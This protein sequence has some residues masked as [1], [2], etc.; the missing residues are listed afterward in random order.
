VYRQKALQRIFKHFAKIG[1]TSPVRQAT[2]EEMK[3]ENKCIDLQEFLLFCKH[4]EVP[5][6][7]KV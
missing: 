3:K 7:S 5:L 4:F 2:F 1:G 6:N